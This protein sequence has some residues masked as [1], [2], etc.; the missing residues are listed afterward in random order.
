MEISRPTR[1]RIRLLCKTLKGIF[2]ISYQYRLSLDD[3]RALD[4][5]LILKQ[6]IKQLLLSGV[7]SGHSKPSPGGSPFVQHNIQPHFIDNVGKLLCR[8]RVL[9][10]EERRVG[11]ERMLVG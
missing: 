1:S 5:H 2:V 4:Q 10:S 7:L 8:H 11:K 9:R 3:Q 6:Q